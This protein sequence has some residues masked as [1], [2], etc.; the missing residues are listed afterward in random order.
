MHRPPTLHDR[1]DLEP[2]RHSHAPTLPIPVMEPRDR[3]AP[4]IGRLIGRII[5]LSRYIL[6]VFYL[7]LIVAL[8]IYA[9]VYARMIYAMA[10]SYDEMSGVEALATM[11]SLIDFALVASL[12]VMVII[13][14]YENFVGPI[15]SDSNT[16]ISWLAR[17]DPGALKIKIG[18]TIITISSIYLLKVLIDVEQYRSHD[19]MWKLAIFVTFI[20]AA[21]ALVLIDRIGVVYRDATGKGRIVHD[22]AHTRHPDDDV[23]SGPTTS[24]SPAPPPKG[25][26]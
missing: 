7:G 9:A 23:P 13:S 25:S 24:T 14:N 2:V 18:A 21:L 20:L 12:A 10:L 19:L 6:V 11:L 5:V 26:H 22:A 1:I 8:G 16:A 17:L 4:V 3:A 15:V